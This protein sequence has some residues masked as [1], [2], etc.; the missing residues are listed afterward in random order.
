MEYELKARKNRNFMQQIIG[1]KVTFW[2]ALKIFLNTT[3]TQII[4]V[5]VPMDY[6]LCMIIWKRAEVLKIF[7]L[8]FVKESWKVFASFKDNKIL[9][10]HLQLLLKYKCQFNISKIKFSGKQSKRS[11]KMN[12]VIQKRAGWEVTW[13]TEV[14]FQ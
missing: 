10:H 12:A 7:L 13:T 11:H 4:S 5:I 3:R 6:K 14:R 1:I 8:K 2:V 9:L